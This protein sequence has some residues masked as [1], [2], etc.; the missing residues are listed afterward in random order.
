MIAREVINALKILATEA[1]I[2]RFLRQ[3]YAQIPRTTL[4]Y[5]IECMD[6]R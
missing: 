5:A 1:F 4:R 3:N 2:K 6:K